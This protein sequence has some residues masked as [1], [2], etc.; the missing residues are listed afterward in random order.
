[1]VV[2]PT[3]DTNGSILEVGVDRIRDDCFA[4]YAPLR[5]VIRGLSF[6]SKQFVGQMILVINIR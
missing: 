4:I 1:M 2:L 3:N 5:R 6:H